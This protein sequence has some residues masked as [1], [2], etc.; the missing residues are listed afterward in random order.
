MFTKTISY[1]S[2]H[3]EARRLRASGKTTEQVADIF[4][5]SVGT[6]GAIVSG[7]WQAYL[8][9]FNDKNRQPIGYYDSLIKKGGYSFVP[10]PDARTPKQVEEARRLERKPVKREEPDLPRLREFTEVKKPHEHKMLKGAI[11][12]CG[13][14]GKTDEYFNYQGSVSTE[15]LPKE[16]T[17]KGWFV[18]NNARQDRC[19][20][21]IAL[22]RANIR[23]PEE[24]PE[25]KEAPVTVQLS[26]PPEPVAGLPAIMIKD[27]IRQMDRLDKRAIFAKLDEVYDDKMYRDDW[28][29]EMVAKDLGVPIDWVEQVR[30]ADFGENVNAKSLLQA[31]ADK[32]KEL[33]DLSQKIDHQIILIDKKLEQLQSLDGKVSGAFNGIQAQVD[34]FEEL[35]KSLEIEDKH[36]KTL[37]EGFDAKVDEFKKMYEELRS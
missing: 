4:G 10:N 9:L 31:S 11:I 21:C 30:A 29:D 18:G 12:K 24:K 2:W 27:G 14:C 28:S 25:E 20:E 22:L 7:K 36:I 5:A 37:I 23:K 13:K 19:P 34:R 26:T 33:H 35:V 32:T 8:A 15:H 17:R 1:P 16:F 3:D 6:M